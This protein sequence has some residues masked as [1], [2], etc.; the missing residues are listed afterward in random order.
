MQ[1]SLRFRWLLRA[2]NQYNDLKENLQ[3]FLTQDYPDYKVLVVVDNS[4]DGSDELIADLSR[5][6]PKLNFVE[7][8]QN[9]NWFSGRKFPLSLG[10]KSAQNNLILLSDPKCKPES[11]KWIEQMV[12]AYLPGKELIIGYSS[13][14][15]KSGI[16]RWL[17]FTAF[18]DAL[19]YIS[20]AMGGLP[21]KGIEK[22]PVIL[23]GS[24]L[25]KKR[26]LFTLCN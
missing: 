13:F 1:I 11:N 12:S 16:N 22:K 18:Y 6:F 20:M 5:Q 8:K 25:P 19:F 15:T 4:D 7:L 9:L 21:Y 3:H 14:D 17:R 26:F 23:A 2:S 24:V 10:I